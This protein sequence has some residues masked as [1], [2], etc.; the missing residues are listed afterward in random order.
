MEYEANVLGTRRVIDQPQ[1][2][3]RVSQFPTAL[4]EFPATQSSALSHILLPVTADMD[5]SRFSKQQM[6]DL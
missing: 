3:N 5:F 6:P 2:R 4:A 1:G